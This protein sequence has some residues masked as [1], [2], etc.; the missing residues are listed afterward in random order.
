MRRLFLFWAALA[1]IVFSAA[2]TA[3][4]PF[5]F[6]DT[7]GKLPKEVVPIDYFI[8]IIPNID[9]LTFT[10]TETIKL[11][12]RSPVHQLVLNALE[13]TIETASLDG[14]ALPKSAIEIDKEKELLT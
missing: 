9:K 12:V 1:S 14:K 4:K 7:P 10:G 3:E 13:L 5:S 6:K 8:R 2:M 11:N